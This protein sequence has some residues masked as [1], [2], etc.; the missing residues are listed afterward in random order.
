MAAVTEHKVQVVL[1][2]LRELLVCWA[3]LLAISD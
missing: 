2:L 3:N 1:G